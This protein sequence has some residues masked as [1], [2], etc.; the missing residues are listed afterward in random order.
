[1]RQN[2]TL[3]TIHFLTS[4]LQHNEAKRKDIGELIA[5]PY[6]NTSWIDHQKLSL[7]HLNNC[8]N[9][10]SFN[11]FAGIKETRRA[12]SAATRFMRGSQEDHIQIVF[13]AK[14]QVQA[15][16]IN[17][18]IKEIMIASE[19]TRDDT[20]KAMQSNSSKSP[21]FQNE[22]EAKER[23]SSKAADRQNRSNSNSRFFTFALK[24][25]VPTLPQIKNVKNDENQR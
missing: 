21:K 5:H 7:K 9:L 1:M 17:D 6:I 23:K 13:N 2:L 4:C 15:D 11:E 24:E 10:P 18:A 12:Q 19:K 3:E 16:K 8:F 20:L 22:E 25:Q 14:D